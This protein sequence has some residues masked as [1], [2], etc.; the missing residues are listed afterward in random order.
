MFPFSLPSN[1]LSLRK[2]RRPI[3]F[4]L[5]FFPTAGSYRVFAHSSG[6]VQSGS[7]LGFWKVPGASVGISPGLLIGLAASI[8]GPSIEAGKWLSIRS[9]LQIPRFS[10]YPLFRVFR[11]TVYCFFHSA[12]LLLCLGLA[13]D[14]RTLSLLGGL[15]MFKVGQPFNFIL[16]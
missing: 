10:K 7:V 3:K 1:G 16:I 8:I 11:Y 2:K 9:L 4:E 15:N 5:A 14:T 13:H 12:S 6:A